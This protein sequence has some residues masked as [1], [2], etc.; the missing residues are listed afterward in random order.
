VPHRGAP[1]AAAGALDDQATHQ[2]RRALALL[3]AADR[4]GSTSV[5]RSLSREATIAASRAR[6][7]RQRAQRL[8]ALAFETSSRSGQHVRPAW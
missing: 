1:Y 5:A 6:A 4:V 2:Q 3:V 8:R 7:V